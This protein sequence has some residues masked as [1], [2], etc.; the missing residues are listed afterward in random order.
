V[1]FI[2]GQ[3]STTVKIYYPDG[4]P[5]ADG[6]PTV[7]SIRKNSDG[8]Y[9]L[10]GVKLCGIS[11]GAAYG[12]DWEM[13]SNYPIV[14]LTNSG[15]NVYYARTFNWS[16][17]AIQNPNPVTAEFTLPAGLPSGDYA[18]EVVA[19]GN[20]SGGVDFV[21]GGAAGT[22]FFEAESLAIN[23]SSDTVDLVNDANY[24]NDQGDILRSNSVGD[25]VTY[26]VPNI[27]AGTYT[28]SVG[29]KKNTNRGQFQLSGSRAD[30]DTWNALPNFG[31][32]SKAHRGDG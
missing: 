17:S 3:H 27:S 12:D 19:N 10:T 25:S 22:S 8:S 4:A 21:T 26:L 14:R 9:H 2:G 23:A 13:D 6:K 28:V 30:L 5:L 7:Q 16:N 18:L 31:Y 24:S 11:A 29:M 32:P 1:F 20:P 15:G